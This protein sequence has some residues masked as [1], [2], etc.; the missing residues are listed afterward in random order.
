MPALRTGLPLPALLWPLGLLAVACEDDAQTTEVGQSA[1]Q[2]ASRSDQTPPE[3]TLLA[4]EQGTAIRDAKAVVRLSA[5]DPFRWFR[6]S[7]IDPS[8]AS[9][10]VNGDDVSELLVVDS[11]PYLLPWRPTSI[12]YRPEGAFD[13]GSIAFEASI[14]D[15]AGN[16]T[17]LDAEFLVDTAG[18]SIAPVSPDPADPITDVTAPL[19]YRIEDALSD[20]DPSTLE[21]TV[22]GAPEDALFQDGE[23]TIAPPDAGWDVGPL[24]IAISIA[25]DLGNESSR[26]LA[27]DVAMQPQGLL[28]LPRAVPTGGEAPLQVRLT[29][30][31]ETTTAIELYEWDF[32]GDGEYDISETV[33][34]DQTFVYGEPGTYDVA[35]RITDSEGG[36]AIGVV[37]ITV[38]NGP[39]QVTAEAF[40]SNGAPPLEVR[41][42]A[43]AADP[44]GVASYEWDFD[45]DGTFDVTATTPEVVHTFAEPGIFQPALR[46]TDTLGA[47]TELAVPTIGVRVV[48]GAPSVQLL[49]APGSGDAPLSVTFSATVTD[50]EG[51]TVSEWEWDF[52]GDGSTD[53]TTDQSVAMHLYGVPG[54]YYARVRA[55]MADGRAGEDVAQ[56]SVGLQADL[57]ISSDTIDTSLGETTTVDTTLSGETAI[58]LVIETPTGEIVRTLVDGELRSPGTYEDPWDG[59][60]DAGDVVA[61]GEYRAVLVYDVGGDSRRLDLGL[62]T[63]GLQS[64][65]PRTTIPPQ[66][67]PF[68][69][70]PLVVDYTLS[71]PSE[72][73][74]FMGRYNVNTRFIT[75][76]QRA[77]RGRGTHTIVWN[78]E[79]GDGQLVHPPDGD[80]FL[81]GVFAYTL[82]DNAIFVRS[83]VHVTGV[84][85]SPSILMPADL[86]R[87]GG[88]NASSVGFTL[89]RAGSVELSIYDATT[90][91]LVR[92]EVIADLDK[93]EQ[94]VEW[95]G[96]LENGAYTAPG[97][98]RIGVAGID[99][100]NARSTAVYALQR[101]YY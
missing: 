35:L 23:L 44:D 6:T 12:E 89:N 41:F 76:E 14:Q 65:P 22:Q 43:T 69:G 101:V 24:L 34:A 71:R 61:E 9:L 1:Y 73:T 48:V 3:L 21:V 10:S 27:Y 87:D 20:V 62:T 81:F 52:D 68:A 57:Q 98:Y 72:V 67:A 25:D 82:P 19:V 54:L 94:T 42:V 15:R 78:G 50:P 59:K 32:D 28:A 83:G 58:D 37:T 38:G 60:D 63:G 80:A 31:V 91:A 97:R 46:V 11:P 33:G 51:L 66:F 17:V 77:V 93:G 56:V 100:R 7:F 92:R 95:D 75:F 49:A 5:R 29:P 30:D 55:T 18:P 64:N 16:E 4:P 86:G 90:G 26:A 96:R 13:D 40:P 45:G 47:S 88:L 8:T 39:P 36:Q 84:S 70:R 2:G 53:T 79:N 99:E 74:S 85:A